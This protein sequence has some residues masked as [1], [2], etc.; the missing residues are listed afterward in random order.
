MSV[1]GDLL[2]SWARRL[3]HPD[4]TGYFHWIRELYETRYGKPI[5]NHGKNRHPTKKGP[6]RRR[7]LKTGARPNEKFYRTLHRMHRS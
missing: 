4:P 2:T 7:G 5:G 1:F 3:P 6:G